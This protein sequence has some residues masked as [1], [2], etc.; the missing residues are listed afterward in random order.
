MKQAETA[1]AA[2]NADAKTKAALDQIETGK[3]ECKDGDHA[4]GVEHLRH[5]IASM[6]MKPLA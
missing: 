5:G 3:K 4:K 2:H 6:G 1:A